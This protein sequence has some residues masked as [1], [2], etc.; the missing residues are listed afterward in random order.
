MSAPTGRERQPVA[1]I[2][3]LPV[4]ALHANDYNPNKVARPEM[5]LLRLSL[6]ENGW[7][8]PIVAR[9]DGEIV[10]G[11]HRWTLA[12]RDPEVAALTGGLV[13]VARLRG[14][15][16]ASQRMATIRHNRA[17]GS[18][19]VVRMADIVA[20]LASFGVEPPEI[21]R[22]LGMEA[23][24]VRRLLHRGA[25]LATPDEFSRGWA[26]AADGVIPWDAPAD[27]RNGDA[28]RIPDPDRAPV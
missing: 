12:S 27:R 15:D 18:H 13:P 6:L 16:P 21:G 26:P 25:M 20:E 3:W 10:D 4:S 24:E 17:R 23:E 9:E 14:L 19:L 28:P 2:E 1:S 5:A 11:F 22:R 8:Q 7:T